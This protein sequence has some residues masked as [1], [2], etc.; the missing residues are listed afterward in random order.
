MQN[1]IEWWKI[2]HNLLSNIWLIF[3][4]SRKHECNLFWG[5][6]TPT[7]LFARISLNHLKAW[8]FTFHE[9]NFPL[10]AIPDK[11]K[12]LRGPSAQT[13]ECEQN[14]R[15]EKTINLIV[16]PIV[17]I[18]RWLVQMLIDKLFYFHFVRLKWKTQLLSLDLFYIFRGILYQNHQQFKEAI[19]CFQKSIQYRPSLACKCLFTCYS[20][21]F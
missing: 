17:I 6:K 18:T 5:A 11:C 10:F 8:T 19:D 20:S 2:Y 1:V 9:D 4:L 15:R 3:K 12:S 16:C 21:I 14:K 13:L 7:L